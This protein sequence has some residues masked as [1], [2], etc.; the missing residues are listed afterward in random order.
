MLRPGEMGGLGVEV[1]DLGCLGKGELSGA[2]GLEPQIPGPWVDHR[3]VS[4]S[5]ST[6]MS[7]L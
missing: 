6:G 5:I 3:P 7:H 1:L 4:R 2:E